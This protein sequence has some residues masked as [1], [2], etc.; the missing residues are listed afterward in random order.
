MKY[1][2]LTHPELYEGETSPYPDEFDQKWLEVMRRPDCMEYTSRLV[3][4][5][6][7][8]PTQEQMT[9]HPELTISCTILELPFTDSNI[10][11]A[12]KTHDP[13]SHH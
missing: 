10:V 4:F 8:A 7:V 2:D 3:P 11:K 13:D 1:T 5:V 12:Y 6:S 9:R